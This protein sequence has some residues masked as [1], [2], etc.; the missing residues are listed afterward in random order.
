MAQALFLSLTGPTARAA[1]ELAFGRSAIATTVQTPK[2]NDKMTAGT[3]GKAGSISTRNPGSLPLSNVRSYQPRGEAGSSAS[4]RKLLA[5]RV[6][7]MGI[8]ECYNRKGLRRDVR[9]LCYFEYTVSDL[10]MY[11]ITTANELSKSTSARSLSIQ[12][13]ST[14]DKPAVALYHLAMLVL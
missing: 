12:Q 13:R 1:R 11:M 4:T 5:E 10:L 14:I 8:G 6:S 9:I 2:A 3:D 7:Q